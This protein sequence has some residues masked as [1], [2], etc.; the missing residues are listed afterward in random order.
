MT[1]K[2]FHQEIAF[3]EKKKQFLSCGDHVYYDIKDNKLTL[4]G[5]FEINTLKQIIKC[6][7]ENFPVK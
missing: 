5:D 6:I 4:D 1:I 3:D 7:E 2:N